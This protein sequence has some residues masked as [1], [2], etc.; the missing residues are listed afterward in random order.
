MKM[1]AMSGADKMN[2]ITATDEVIAETTAFAVSIMP[3]DMPG[4][5]GNGEVMN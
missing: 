4:I 3:W 1:N 2:A 5:D